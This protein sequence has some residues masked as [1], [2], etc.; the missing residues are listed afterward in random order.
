MF[1]QENNLSAVEEIVPD[2]FGSWVFP[3]LLEHR[4]PLYE[5]LAD[6]HGYAVDLY[7]LQQVRDEEDFIELV[8][9]SIDRS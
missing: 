1:M 8:C 4:K 2:E 6:Q 3:K 5:A 9:Q 7:Q